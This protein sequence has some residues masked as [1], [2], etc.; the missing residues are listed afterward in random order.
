MSIDRRAH[1][2]GFQFDVLG[3]VQEGCVTYQDDDEERI[4]PWFR[5]GQAQEIEV[6]WFYSALDPLRSWVDCSG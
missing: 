5:M 6:V 4:F 3:L 2:A 1:N